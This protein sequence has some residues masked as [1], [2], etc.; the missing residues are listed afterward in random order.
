MASLL[1]REL[2]SIHSVDDLVQRHAR[3][4]DLLTCRMNSSGQYDAHEPGLIEPGS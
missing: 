4:R 3:M 2:E 1:V